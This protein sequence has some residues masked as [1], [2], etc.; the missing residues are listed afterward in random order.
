MLLLYFVMMPFGLY[1]ARY[2][3]NQATWLDIHQAIM[4]IGVSE[5]IASA[6]GAVTTGNL[7]FDTPHSIIGLFM[8]CFGLVIVCAGW[9]VKQDL[10]WSLGAIR[11]IRLCHKM[12]GRGF[13]LLGVVNC[14]IGLALVLTGFANALV[15]LFTTLFTGL[16]FVLAFLVSFHRWHGIMYLEVIRLHARL[17]RPSHEF[18]VLEDAQ[19]DQRRSKGRVLR[20]REW[21][22]FAEYQDGVHQQTGIRI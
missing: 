4:A 10:Q 3:P 20:H 16:V 7:N 18:L 14:F 12:S 9:L 22:S 11:F 8:A 13:F 6:L 19:F 5:V 17:S 2:W 1:A 15:L 21:K